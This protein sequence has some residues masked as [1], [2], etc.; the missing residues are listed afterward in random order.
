MNANKPEQ[1]HATC[2]ALDG[3]GVLLRGPSGS[4]KSD[5]ALRLIDAGA[6]LVADDRVDLSMA[7]GFLTASAPPA[8]R[9]LLEVRGLGILRFPALTAAPVAVVCNL[10]ATQDVKRHPE[11][12]CTTILGVELPIFA[13]APFEASAILKVQLALRLTIGSIMRAHDPN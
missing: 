9:D 13:L 8:L 5:M 4:G 7:E 1:I 12:S 11:D 10:V 2:I 6:E 3:Q